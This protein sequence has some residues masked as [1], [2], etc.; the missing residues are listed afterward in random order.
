MTRRI[1]AAVI[2]SSDLK[3][4]EDRF[5]R[6]AHRLPDSRKRTMASISARSPA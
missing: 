2:A 1:G 6:A 4:L 5:A 3:V